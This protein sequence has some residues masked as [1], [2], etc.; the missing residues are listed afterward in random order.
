MSLFNTA[1]FWNFSDT[2]PFIGV[3]SIAWQYGFAVV[4][5]ML[6]GSF[7][8]VVIN[9]L[10]P[11]EE[12]TVNRPTWLILIYPPSHCPQCLHRL[13]FWENIPIISF[14]ILRGRCAACKVAISMRYPFLEIASVGLAVLTLWNFGA[15]WQWLAALSLLAGLFALACIDQASYILPD[16]LTLPLLWAGLW[17]NAN[18][19]FTTPKAAIFGAIAGYALLWCVYWIFFLVRKKEGL[20]YGDFKLL[21]AIGAWQGIHALPQI[22]W[23]ASLMGVLI[24]GIGQVYR[25]VS[26][27]AIRPYLA[28]GPFLAF[29][30]AFTLF[31]PGFLERYLFGDLFEYLLEYLAV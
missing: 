25:L 30:A 31:M 23:M 21:A 6:I 3:I 13:R 17:V 2:L 27:Q 8:S 11:K 7:L 14:L 4:M 29:S 19:G 22:V 10:T 12:S 1:P 5:G 16:T 26:K 9:R 20:G 24:G 28:F 18:R 15:T